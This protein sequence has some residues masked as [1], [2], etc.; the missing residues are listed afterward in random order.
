MSPYRRS[1]FPAFYRPILTGLWPPSR[2]FD[3][4]IA[5][6]V[7]A[8][9]TLCAGIPAI[10]NPC[11]F[12]AA[13]VVSLGLEARGERAS[14]RSAPASSSLAVQPSGWGA[15]R[16]PWWRGGRR[17]IGREAGVVTAM[18]QVSRWHCYLREGMSLG[19]F[20]APLT[21]GSSDAGAFRRPCSDPARI[22]RAHLAMH[23]RGCRRDRPPCGGRT[24]RAASSHLQRGLGD[25]CELDGRTVGLIPLELAFAHRFSRCTTMVGHRCR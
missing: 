10:R 5:P 18:K 3:L 17:N 21:L 13:L 4:G 7:D 16:R 1:P 24:H 8:S 2:S 15:L 14:L 23:P 6:E 20:Q 9:R 25:P 19:V 11:S 22:R 12:A